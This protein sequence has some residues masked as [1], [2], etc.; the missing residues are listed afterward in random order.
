MIIRF[1]RDP[2]PLPRALV[3]ITSGE[4]AP[5][6]AER[7]AE[8]VEQFCAQYPVLHPVY[9]VTHKPDRTEHLH[10]VHMCVRPRSRS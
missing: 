5:G 10:M 1:S 6:T 2:Y 9:S 4:L 3:R 7:L 8:I